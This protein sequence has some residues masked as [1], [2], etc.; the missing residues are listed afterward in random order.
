MDTQSVL[1]L[2]KKYD[3]T[4]VYVGPLERGKYNP[5]ALAKFDRFMDVVFQ[6]GDVTIYKRRP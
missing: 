5:A 1:T 6:Q 4:Y 3:I 2:L